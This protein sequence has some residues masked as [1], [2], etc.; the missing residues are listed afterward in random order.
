MRKLLF[1]SARCQ[2]RPVRYFL[3]SRTLDNETEEYG[4][5]VELGE[6][7]V[8]LPGLTYSQREIQSLLDAMRRGIVTPVTARDVAEDWLLRD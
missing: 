4:A 8:E 1:G 6:E 2:D 5:A 3:L 7:R